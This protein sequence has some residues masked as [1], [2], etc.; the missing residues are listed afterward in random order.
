MM[1]SQCINDRCGALR[2]SCECYFWLACDLEHL[3][4]TGRYIIVP[5]IRKIE[6]PFLLNSPLA[7]FL[8][9]IAYAV[10]AITDNKDIVA[11]QSQLDR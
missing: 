1:L 6:V 11:A 5:H 7:I 2:V 10:P 4:N 9:S 8:V 3:V